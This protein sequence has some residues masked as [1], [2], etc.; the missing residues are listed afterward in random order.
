MGTSS[1]SDCNL[2]DSL[3]VIL[4]D[5]GLGWVM[6][7]AQLQNKSS[8]SP[9]TIH[10][11]SRGKWSEHKTQLPVLLQGWLF[12]YAESKKQKRK[13]DQNKL[14]DKSHVTITSG[15]HNQPVPIDLSRV[16]LPQSNL[17]LYAILTTL[18]MKL[19]KGSW[20]DLALVS[21]KIKPIF[22]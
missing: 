10:R 18:I 4:D 3:P 14:K 9:R 20:S 7:I 8:P 13:W 11:T 2:S 12:S 21:I 6:A 19:L 5:A 1:Q 17:K 22:M 16:S 15:Q